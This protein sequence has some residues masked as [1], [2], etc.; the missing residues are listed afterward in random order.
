MLRRSGAVVD[1]YGLQK[2]FRKIP[3]MRQYHVDIVKYI[4]SNVLKNVSFLETGCGI[5]QT[6]VV[7]NRCGYSNFVGIEKDWS[8]AT[9]AR[10]FL[11]SYGIDAK[12][13]HDDGL[14]ADK[15]VSP[16]SM[17]VYLPLNWTYFTPEFE[18][19]FD[20]GVNV[21]KR[22]GLM[23]ID[24]IRDDYSPSTPKEARGY[25]NYP[26]KHSIEEIIRLAASKGLTLDR[27]DEC[28]GARS[29]LYLKRVAQGRS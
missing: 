14:G 8:T 4:Q 6:F 19:V 23:V 28:Y 9:A 11:S 5:G 27:L 1:R 29:N 25:D 10:D 16:Q 7:L 15:W 18:R 24:I 3:A 20:I 13:I 2:W 17:D 12:I 21:L 26:Q 22:D